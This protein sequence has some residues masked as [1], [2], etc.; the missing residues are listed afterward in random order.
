LPSDVWD[1][2]SLLLS[3]FACSFHSKIHNLNVSKPV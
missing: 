2:Q 3:S 1:W